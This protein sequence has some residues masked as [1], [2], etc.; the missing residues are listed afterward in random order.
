MEQANKKIS[1]KS[2][3]VA[4]IEKGPGND[5]SDQKDKQVDP[6]PFASAK[7]LH[8]QRYKKQ[9]TYQ[10]RKFKSQTVNFDQETSNEPLNAFV[11]D[12]FLKPVKKMVDVTT[13]KQTLQIK[14]N[15]AIGP[16][17]KTLGDK[18]LDVRNDPKTQFLQKL[19]AMNDRV[20]IYKKAFL[21]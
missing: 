17:D 14:L 3:T 5:N 8:K 13:F 19:S 9:E 1:K 4:D 15:S 2:K 6:N 12:L 7:K 16:E 11:K 20:K 18:P 21:V 10:Q